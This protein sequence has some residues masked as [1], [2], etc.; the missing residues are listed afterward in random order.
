M[1]KKCHVTCTCCHLD[2]HL[3]IFVK[4]SCFLPSMLKLMFCNATKRYDEME[5]DTLTVWCN[6]EIIEIGLFLRCRCSYSINFTINKKTKYYQYLYLANHKQ[7]INDLRVATVLS[8]VYLIRDTRPCSVEVRVILSFDHLREDY[9]N[10][11]RL[12]KRVLSKTSMSFI[13]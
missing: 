1:K 11:L 6:A 7:H 3:F 8:F 10:E 5:P 9:P 2:C 4:Q 12:Y 13:S